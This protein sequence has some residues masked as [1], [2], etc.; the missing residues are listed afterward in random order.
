MVVCESRQRREAV[1]QSRQRRDHRASD[2]VLKCLSEEPQ[3][4][5]P[6]RSSYP[7]TKGCSRNPKSHP[8]LTPGAT[9]ENPVEASLSLLIVCLKPR[10]LDAVTNA[11]FEARS[12][13][14]L[15]AYGGKTS[16]PLCGW[17][18][19]L[20]KK[21]G[22]VPSVQNLNTCQFPSI[23]LIIHSKL[24]HPAFKT[25]MYT[26]QSFMQGAPA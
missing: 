11:T 21:C 1:L 9:P 8:L 3:K 23:D 4:N 17:S 13:F 5:S 2:G 7:M 14:C 22:Y 15:S 19:T 18:L 6:Y 25:E 24:R 12:C 26:Y 16:H 10:A 20:M